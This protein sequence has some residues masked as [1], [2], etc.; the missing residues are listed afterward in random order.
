MPLPEP[1]ARADALADLPGQP[2]R[3]RTLYR[4]WRRQ[5][6]DGT[7]RESPWWFSSLTEPPTFS[8]RFDLAAPMGTCYLASRPEA[9]VLEALQM[10][11][12]NLPAE[13]L[14]VRRIAHIRSPENA[15][16]AAMLTA[17]SVVGDFGITPAIWAGNDR[18]LSQRWAAAIRRDGWW[19]V[20]AGI[21]H[22][23][24][25]QLRAVALFDQAGDH[26]PTHGKTWH[27]RGHPIESDHALQ[28]A[29]M[30]Y[31]VQVREPGQLEWARPP[32]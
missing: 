4:V 26:A 18:R 5:L 13:E 30:R 21:A 11:L 15:P 25:G 20:Y 17:E 12:R 23:P 22:D 16:R 3:R 14:R 2:L 24:R 7:T 9:A 28:Q 1:P 10:H 29:L 6:P 8:G 31:G 27:W 32:D 19:A